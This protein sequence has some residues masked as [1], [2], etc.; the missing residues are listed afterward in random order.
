LYG[1]GDY[2]DNNNNVVAV[3]IILEISVKIRLINILFCRRYR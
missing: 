2:D 1:A 3:V